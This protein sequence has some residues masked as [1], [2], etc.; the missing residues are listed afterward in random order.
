MI[1]YNIVVNKV[2]L[3]LTKYLKDTALLNMILIN[4][5]SEEKDFQ[6]GLPE[7]Q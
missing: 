4:V 5:N 2:I 6:E 3:T 7:S 1:I